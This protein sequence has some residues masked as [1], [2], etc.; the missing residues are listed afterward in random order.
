MMTEK[1]LRDESR[2]VAGDIELIGD[3]AGTD[4]IS[5]YKTGNVPL[6]A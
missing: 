3:G 6:E 1:R 5:V 2:T 4:E